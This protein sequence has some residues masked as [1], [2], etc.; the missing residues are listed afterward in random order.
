MLMKIKMTRCEAAKQ[1]R[2]VYTEFDED[3]GEFGVFGEHTGFCYFSGTE[4]T[5]N[6]EAEKINS[7]KDV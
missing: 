1:D 6:Q 4:Q 2:S 7:R 3:L 5:C